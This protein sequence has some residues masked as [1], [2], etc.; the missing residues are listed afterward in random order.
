MKG[1]KIV[2]RDSDWEFLDK[3]EK[4][5]EK[6]VRPSLTFLQDG[7]RR[8]TRNRVAVVSMAFGILL[9]AVAVF[10]PMFWQYSYEDQNLRL[11]NVPNVLRVY[12][13]GH[14]NVYFITAYYTLIEVK[15]DGRLV[16][17]VDPDRRDLTAKKTTCTIG[18]D[19]VVIDYSG[20]SAA[21]AEYKKFERRAVRSGE[22]AIPV[23]KCGYLGDYFG[24]EKSGRMV[25]V[26]E[27]KAILENHVPRFILTVNGKPVAE[28]KRLYNKTYIMGTDNL[29][30][31]LFIRIIYGARISL[32]VAFVAA[33]V[34]FLIG[35]T[36]GA[37]SGYAG[38][39]CDMVMMRIV[40][41]ISSIPLMLYVILLTVIMGGGGLFAI[42]I[43]LGLTHW[44]GMARIVRGQVLSCKGQEFVLAARALGA[45]SRRIIVKHLVPNMMGPIMVYLAM[46][47]PSAI[48]SE[49]FLSFVG[50]GISAPKASWGTLCNDALESIY[51]NPY[52]ILFPAAAI[53]LTIL[54]FN[55][56]SD[57]LRDA[58]D[59]KQRK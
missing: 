33:A 26:S 12:D 25:S 42:I 13:I 11:A 18:D 58:L 20:Y 8:L 30:R 28:T 23:D 43:A 55:L 34:N 39:R 6:I 22:D 35:V 57:G 56:F 21:A 54:A 14:E 27:A 41:I 3:T 40:D 32:T 45:D 19:A 48:F 31:D 1:E 7:W 4:D 5:A 24:D 59:P 36:Y 2:M 17:L 49:A 29:G 38:G 51:T 44:M 47:I 9:L 46:Q 37:I 52:Q 10:V 16:D 50:L 53:S 15:R